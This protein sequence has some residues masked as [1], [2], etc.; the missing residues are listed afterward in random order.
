LITTAPVLLTSGEVAIKA[1]SKP[2]GND[3]CR[4]THK[5]PF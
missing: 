1:H 2:A 4:K 3:Y 5:K